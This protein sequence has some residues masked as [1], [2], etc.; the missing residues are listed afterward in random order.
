MSKTPNNIMKWVTSRIKGN[1][2]IQHDK[3]KRSPFALFSEY[4]KIFKSHPLKRPA[5]HNVDI[6]I[7]I[8]WKSQNKIYMK[9]P[10]VLFHII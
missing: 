7:K 8:N 3:R 9:M 2:I 5:S 4:Q 1:F 10:R 6:F